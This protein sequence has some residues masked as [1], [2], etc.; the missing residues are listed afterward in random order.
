[1][2]EVENKN[3]RSDSEV[4]PELQQYWRYRS[5]STFEGCPSYW[6]HASSSGGSG[7]IRDGG[8]ANPIA[9]LKNLDKERSG[10]EDCQELARREQ[11]PA[12]YE[13]KKYCGDDPILVSKSIVWDL[14]EMTVNHQLLGMDLAC[15]FMGNPNHAHVKSALNASEVIETFKDLSME[16]S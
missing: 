13:R 4:P 3:W 14:I 6:K 9:L 16:E 10:G 5:R 15:R 11:D 7:V 1:M 2:Q 12:N 8:Y